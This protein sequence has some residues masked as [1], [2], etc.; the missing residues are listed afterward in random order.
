MRQDNETNLNLLYLENNSIKKRESGGKEV[1]KIHVT[2][3]GGDLSNYR[4]K[5]WKSGIQISNTYYTTTFIM[6]TRYVQ[7]ENKKII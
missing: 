4:I 1:K 2:A 3:D 5:L 7:K 6:S